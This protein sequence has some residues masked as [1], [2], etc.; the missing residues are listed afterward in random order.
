MRSKLAVF[1]VF[2]M[3]VLMT[4]PAYANVTSL[5]LEKGFYTIDENFKFVGTQEGK[6]T[7]FTSSGR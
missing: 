7:V 3:F 6:D 2:F 5:S 4:M 1:S